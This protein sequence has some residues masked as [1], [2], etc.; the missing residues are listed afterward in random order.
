MC[1]LFS[2]PSALAQV[3][4]PCCG[5]AFSR[6]P[7]LLYVQQ[8]PICP[9]CRAGL[10]ASSVSALPLNRTLA[11][12][13]EEA[14]GDKAASNADMSLDGGTVPKGSDGAVPGPRWACTL[15]P[16]VTSAGMELD[17][18][19]LTLSLEW[20]DF[21][22]DVCLFLPVIDKSGSMSGQPFKQVVPFWCFPPCLVRLLLS[23]NH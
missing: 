19:R 17:V 23:S 20:P 1:I 15:T 5:R 3:S 8:S 2:H 12:L 7:L 11:A 10:I 6:A 22:G 16:V 18:D 9:L 14:A 13:V 21:E 4:S